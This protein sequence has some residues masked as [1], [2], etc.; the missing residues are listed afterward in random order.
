[1]GRPVKEAQNPVKENLN[2]SRPAVE[3]PIV[4]KLDIPMLN[5]DEDGNIFQK[6]PIMS[7]GCHV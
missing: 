5:E 3:V 4:P 7:V 6:K 1:M 2:Q